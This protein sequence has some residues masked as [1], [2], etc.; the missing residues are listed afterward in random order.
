MDK[1]RHLKHL[2]R[3]VRRR[4]LLLE[5]LSSFDLYTAIIVIPVVGMVHVRLA[6]GLFRTALVELL[7]VSSQEGKERHVFIVI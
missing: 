5:N 4:E 1:S 3:A 7:R 6:T 2:S